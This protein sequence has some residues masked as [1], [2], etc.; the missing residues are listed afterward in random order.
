MA[1]KKGHKDIVQLLL[2]AGAKIDAIDKVILMIHY[3]M[4]LFLKKKIC[5]VSYT[6]I[7]SNRKSNQNKV[8]ELY[9]L[10]ISYAL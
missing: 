9:K 1:A 10:L 4:V 2:S 3:C 7:L 8:M 5:F 6:N